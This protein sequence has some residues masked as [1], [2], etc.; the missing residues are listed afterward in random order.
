[1]Q[2]ILA[3]NE[4]IELYELVAEYLEPEGYKVEAVHD[5]VRGVERALSEDHV[6][7]VLCYMLRGVK[8]IEMLRHISALLAL[9]VWMLPG[10]GGVLFFVGETFDQAG[11]HH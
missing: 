1:M 6:R 3:I 10:R 8:G 4:D 2:Q 5:G 7:A 11:S 9:A